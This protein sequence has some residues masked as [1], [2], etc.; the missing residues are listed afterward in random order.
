M[1]K[2][3]ELIK[4]NVKEILAVDLEKIDLDLPPNDRLG[5]YTFACF[6]LA[7]KLESNPVELAKKLSQKFVKNNYIKGVENVG[8]YLNIFVSD[9]F[10]LESLKKISDDKN[11]HKSNIGKGKKILIEF[12][13]PNT[14]KPQHV[15]HVRND[16]LG[17]ALVNIYKNCNYKVTA[18]NII[19]DRGIHIVKSMLAWKL[20]AKGETPQ[21]SGIKGDHLVGKYYVKFG[22]VYKEEFEKYL[23]E[24][25][26]AL[27]KLDDQEQKKVVDTFNTQSTWM[28]EAHKMLRAWEAN[29]KDVKKLWKTMNSWVYDGY[30]K[31]YSDLGIKFDH[32]VYVS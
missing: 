14:N 15:G 23:E 22:Q 4:K 32:V 25:K 1:E 2:I 9:E 13:G 18:V 10:V 20:F 30:K 29:N 3:H 17:Q 5:D 27:T 7:E 19:N 31:T 28:I 21:S 8:P 16:I 6:T 26:I 12:S 24:K 11:F